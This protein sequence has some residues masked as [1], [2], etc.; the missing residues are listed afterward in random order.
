[1]A[2]TLDK[3]VVAFITFSLFIVAGTFIVTNVNTN[4]DGNVNTSEF[5]GTYDVIDEMYNIS[6]DMKGQTIDADI[7]DD[8]SWESMTKGSYSAVRLVKNTFKLIGQ[9]IEDIADVLHVPQFFVVFAITAL[10]VT[11]IFAVIFL[12]MRFRP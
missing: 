11:I 10:T 5:S 3:F 1:M 7:N 6:Q 8:E 2:F 4:Y 12:F 9:I